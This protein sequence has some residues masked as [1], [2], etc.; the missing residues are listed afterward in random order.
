MMSTQSSPVITDMQVIPVA[1][2]DSMLM[3][4]GGAHGA[5]FTRNIVILKDS[6]GNTGVGEAPGG[7]VIYN[8]LVEAIAQVK[9]QEVAR[10]NRLV[11]QI[12]V[13]NQSSDFDSFGKGAWTFELRVNAVAALEAALLDL[14]GKFLGVPVCELLGPGKQRDE[15]T[16]LGY[17]FYIGDRQK[18]D[19][20]YQEGERSHHDWYHLR[21]QEAMNSE[22]VVRLAEAAQ[23]RYGFKDFKLKGGVLPGEQEIEAVKALAKRFP[24]ARITVDPNG[25]WLLDEAIDLCKDLHGILSYAEDPCGAEQG[26]SGREV[27]AEF[28]RATGLPVATNMIATNW[29]EMQHAVMLQSVDIPLADPHFWTMHGAVRVAQLCD[30][31]G[32]TWG[33]HSNNHFDISLAMFTHVGAAVPGKPTAIDTHWIWQ[34]GNQRLTKEPLQIV[35]GKI[36]VPEKPGLGV[37]ID[38]DQIHRAHELHRKLPTGARNDAAAMQYLIP[39]WTFDR[40]RPALGRG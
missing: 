31:W 27:M 11:H 3:N 17:L 26:F 29:R 19:L 15:V 16:V 9:G 14:M 36:K 2:H 28:R 21:H 35:N 5:Y 12:H 18:T 22:A 7:E 38:M 37:E 6:A 24:D 1:G 10:M 20:P 23:D 8:T 4:I 30:E 40:K 33:C 32:L 13:G 25:A 39:G 34:E